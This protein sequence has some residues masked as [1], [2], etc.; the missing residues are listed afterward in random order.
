[1]VDLAKKKGVTIDSYKLQDILNTPI[2]RTVA[3]RG[4]GLTDIIDKAI[5]MKEGKWEYAAPRYGKEIETCIDELSESLKDTD[6]QYPVRWAAIKLL[7]KDSDITRLVREKKPEVLERSKQLNMKLEEIHGHDSSVVIADERS[8]LAAQITREIVNIMPHRKASLNDWFDAITTHKTI[9]YL[10]M[11][12][13]PWRH[14][15]HSIQLWELVLRIVRYT[16]QQT[17]IIGG[18]SM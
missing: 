8:H 10:V 1:M 7:E 18:T 17:G 6:L 4:F 13:D 15:P 9:G 16:I 5:E 2:I 3:S 14:V 12:I 11:T